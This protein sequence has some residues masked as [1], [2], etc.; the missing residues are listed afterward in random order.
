MSRVCDICSKKRQVGRQSRHKK[1]VAGKQWA[2]RAPKTVRIFKPNLQN[3]TID[4]KKMRLC[5]KC[6]KKIKKEKTSAQVSPAQPANSAG[7]SA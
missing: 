1:G 6:L 3:A 7:K 4:G 5:A 2:K